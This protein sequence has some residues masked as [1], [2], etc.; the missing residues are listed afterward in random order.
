MSDTVWP[1]V[2]AEREAFVDYVQTLEPADWE[3]AS[4]CD[5]WRVKDVVAHMIAGAKATPITFVFGLITSGFNWDKWSAKA[6]SREANGTPAELTARLRSVVKSKTPPAGAMLGEM[7]VHGEDVRRAL[8]ASA[9]HYPEEHLRAVAE[10][11]K[12]AGAPLRVKK[13]ISG[14]KLQATDV[15]WSTGDGPLVS[16]PLLSLLL[17]MTG[18]RAGLDGLS[19]PGLEDL[20]S[21]M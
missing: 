19:G 2:F 4:L 21:R 12:T 10:Y 18:R 1:M 5:G 16:G 8:G 15:E 11:Y 9:V 13:R 6:A 14:L 20:R 3:H 7:V 17:A